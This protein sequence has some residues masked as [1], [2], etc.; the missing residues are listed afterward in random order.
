FFQSTVEVRAPSPVQMLRQIVEVRASPPVQMLQEIVEA[1]TSPPVQ[2]LQ[3]IVKARAPSPVLIP[4]I[5]DQQASW[6]VL[7]QPTFQMKIK[8]KPHSNPLSLTSAR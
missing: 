1:R 4:K 8:S 7:I 2:I 5:L 6:P 3:Q